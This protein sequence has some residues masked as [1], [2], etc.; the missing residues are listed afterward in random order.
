MDKVLETSGS[1]CHIPSS[2][3][4]RI[5][6]IGNVCNF[7]PTFLFPIS[8]VI[9][10]QSH[11]TAVSHFASR[12]KSFV[13]LVTGWYWTCSVHSSEF[14][15]SWFS[16]RYVISV[17][18]SRRLL[19][20][21]NENFVVWEFSPVRCAQSTRCEPANKEL[22]SRPSIFARYSCEDSQPLSLTCTRSLRERTMP[23][24]ERRKH[25]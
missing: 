10:N 14:K 1:E 23:N 11:N 3:P 16:P 4:F 25:N 21:V 6:Y 24:R 2:K 5:Q 13:W 9:T 7:N 19:A 18:T 8:S 22:L 17:R 15:N 20:C 12:R